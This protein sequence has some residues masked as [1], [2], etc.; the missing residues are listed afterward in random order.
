VLYNSRPLKH[1]LKTLV[2]Q[3]GERASLPD[4]HEVAVTLDEDLR[5]CGHSLV[6]RVMNRTLHESLEVAYKDLDGLV[7]VAEAFLSPPLSTVSNA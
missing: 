3:Y 1:L 6:V 5:Y 7:E 4:L 2:R